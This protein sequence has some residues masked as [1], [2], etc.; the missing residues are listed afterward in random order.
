MSPRTSDLVDGVRE[1]S[2]EAPR[3]TVMVGNPKP[4]SRTLDLAQR[5]AGDIAVQLRSE[6][7]ID[8]DV[9]VAPAIDLAD[10]AAAL[11]DWTSQ[12]L[13]SLVE[14]VRSSALVIVASPTYK[15]SYTGLLKLFVDLF[16][17][18]A[19]LG[20]VTVPLMTG[21]S[22]LHA[23]AVEVHLRPVLVEL[24]A[25]MPTRGLYVVESGLAADARP[26]EAW[27]TTAFRRSPVRC[28][29]SQR[30]S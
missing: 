15:A 25:S 19:L 26:Y 20:T 14:R 5:L 8:V 10:I 13:A 4:G 29:N 23:L 18:N 12:G 30:R 11:L 17:E 3:L 22:D 24:G 9:E 1:R 21:G 7:A 2:I 27:L 16:A 28:T 6:Y